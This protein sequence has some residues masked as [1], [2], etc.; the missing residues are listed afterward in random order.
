MSHAS[1]LR[2]FAGQLSL[3]S[4]GVSAPESERIRPNDPGL[5]VDVRCRA[6]HVTIIR[7]LAAGISR[8]P[9]KVLLVMGHTVN[10]D[11]MDS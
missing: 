9:C 11:E 10:S 2:M 8:R 7:W 1:A 6:A 3:R 4:V 5:F